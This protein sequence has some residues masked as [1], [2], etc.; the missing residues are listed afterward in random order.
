MQN[1]NVGINWIWCHCRF[2]EKLNRISLE[3][4][5]KIKKL[6]FI[7]YISNLFTI[8]Q[9]WFKILFCIFCIT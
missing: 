4:Y 5:F 7:F 1:V 6:V 2:K 3:M 8:E 9:Y